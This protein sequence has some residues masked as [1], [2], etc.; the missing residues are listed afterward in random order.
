MKTN[1]T[2]SL[3]GLCAILLIAV[4]V[5]Q[6]KQQ[7]RLDVLQRQQEVFSSAV[8]RQQQEQRDAAAKVANQVTNLGVNLESRLAQS[9]Q[10]T[11]E[12]IVK[13][14]DNVLTLGTNWLAELTPRLNAK[15]DE[16]VAAFS[17]RLNKKATEA[18]TRVA[19]AM[20]L[21]AE[22][23]LNASA[24]ERSNKTARL[25]EAASRYE[26]DSRPDLAELCYLSAFKC[27]D[28]NPGLV[29]KQFL[30]W[31]ERDFADMSEA[32]MLTAS[33]AKL[34]SL[35]ETLDKVLPDSMTLPDEMEQA[36]TA[37][38]RIRERIT[39]RQKAK[40]TELRG[41]LSW[42]QFDATNRSAYSQAKD[43]LVS[44]SPVNQTLER[45]KSQLQEDAEDLIQTA[46]AM[47]SMSVTD[48]LPPSPKAPSQVL[49]NWFEHGLAL[50]AIPTNAVEARLVGL[51]VLIDFAQ[52]QIE[53]LECKRYAVVLTNESVKLAC[54]QWA[55]RVNQYGELADKKD[56][57]DAD[58]LAVGQSLLNQGFAILKS[59]TNK[60]ITVGVSTSLPGLASKLYSQREMLLVGQMRLVDDPRT[61]PSKEQAA[62]ARGMLSGQMMSTIFDLRAL[63]LEVAKECA[64][65]PYDLA[66]FQDVEG[67]FREYLA[68]YEKLDK[69][70]RLD[71]Q[72]AHLA[73]LRQQYQRYANHCKWVISAARRD[74]RQ[75]EVSKSGFATWG[76]DEPQS[77][78]RRGLQT[79]YSIDI[80]DLNR[81]DPGAASDWSIVEDLL[82]KNYRATPSQ[83]N[84][85]T[86]K[87]TLNDF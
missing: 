54:A 30:A 2:T 17:A 3:C 52:S 76:S 53:M 31:K 8:S 56:K 9:K 50:I 14:S 69:V 75:A 38:E 1:L 81:A 60:T 13:L 28:G 32:N 27:S 59:F 77:D 10:Q 74:Y 79:L 25:L 6:F 58:I 62:R 19:K 40:T 72:A 85:D 80:N 49:T 66:I 82:K 78:L 84:A 47:S 22:A 18:A 12:A 15:S 46:T 57:P 55:E 20:R 71:E 48:L 65:T 7:G 63:Q 41:S 29:L 33:P 51:S 5:L 37:T 67:R 68:A 73:K 42:N 45:E 35:F 23:A 26:K 39:K 34:N 36:L 24:L 70:D 43:V 86:R 11:A 83:I 87:K 64:A 21:Q 61:F 16:I 44:F 4:L